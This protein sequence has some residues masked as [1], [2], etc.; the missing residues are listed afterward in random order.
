MKVG[1]GWDRV[2]GKGGVDIREGERRECDG[3]GGWVTERERRR[4]GD[5]W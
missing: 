4:V 2:V 5:G 3:G 1:V